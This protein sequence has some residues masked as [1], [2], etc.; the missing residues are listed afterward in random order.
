[1]YL[2]TNTKFQAEIEL[3][4]DYMRAFAVEFPSVVADIYR[5]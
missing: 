4:K 3:N 1:M 5:C 2:Y